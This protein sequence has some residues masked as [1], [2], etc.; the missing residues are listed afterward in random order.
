MKRF[1]I[2]FLSV[3]LLA[4]APAQAAPGKRAKLEFRATLDKPSYTRNDP[5]QVTFT[6]TNAGKQP[7]WVNT[8]FYTSSKTAAEEDREVY[9]VVTSPSGRDV[10][11][12]FSHP[13]GLPKTDDFKLLEPGQEAASEN[14]RDLRRFFELKEPGTY[15]VRA[16]YHNVFGAELG[17][18]AAKGPLESK[19]V[20]FS[21]SE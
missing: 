21:V 9:L 15:T 13:T 18:D 1:L 16:V 12:T 19:P 14:P 8:R 3:A 4:D 6:L 11:C 17:L 5:I 2:A 7:A 10:P 20:T